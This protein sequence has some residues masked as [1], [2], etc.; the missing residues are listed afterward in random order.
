MASNVKKKRIS[1][2]RYIFILTLLASLVGLLVYILGAKK[3]SFPSQWMPGEIPK[4]NL[5]FAGISVH[6]GVNIFLSLFFVLLNPDK[7]DQ[8]KL[9][10]WRFWISRALIFFGSLFMGLGKY[11]KNVQGSWGHI[12]L[13]SLIITVINCCLLELLIQLMNQYGICNAFNLILFTEFLPYNWIAKN[14]NKPLPMLCLTFIT[15]LFIWITNLKWEASV[16]TNTLYSQSGKIL[17]KNKTKLG[18]RLSFGF[19]PLIQLAQ[20]IGWIYNLILMRRGG[21]NWSSFGSISEGWKTAEQTRGSNTQSLE[22]DPS[23]SKITQKSWEPFFL[24]N[25]ARYIFSWKKLKNWFWDKKWWIIGGLFFFLLFLRWLS[26]W[27]QMRKINPWKTGEMSKE[28]RSRGIYING[29][30][31]GR[32]TRNLLRKI[33]NKIIFF[34]FFIML[35]F[36]IIFD[37]IFET[38]GMPPLSF[39]SW[40]GGVN[41]GVD[42]FRQIRTKYKFI[43]TNR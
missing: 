40:F 24:L 26:M 38:F 29:V 4:G 8:V 1:R 35:I 20:F 33:I 17:K 27:T 23:I 12:L 43:K 36:N 41:I 32:S 13:L 5:F 28:L 34:W 14:W 11:W 31:P 22:Q 19:M 3:I 42:L 7:M 6:L 21:V 37:N 10:K 18:F 9:R 25:D 15:V 2:Q 30:A 16:E 39:F